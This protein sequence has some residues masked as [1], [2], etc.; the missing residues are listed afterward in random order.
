MLN[1]ITVICRKHGIECQFSHNSIIPFH[2]NPFGFRG[3]AYRWNTY[4]GNG[5]ANGY[6]TY[7]IANHKRCSIS[8]ITFLFSCLGFPRISVVIISWEI[9]GCAVLN[10]YDH[11]SNKKRM[12]ICNQE[13]RALHDYAVPDRNQTPNNQINICHSCE[14]S[15]TWSP[16][17]NLVALQCGD[18]LG[19]YIAFG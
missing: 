14:G 8:I 13:S 12:L 6:H 18:N 17:V 10:L 1:L 9:E 11:P 4:M 16:P 5:C 7:I 15:W 3:I 19:Y 2:V